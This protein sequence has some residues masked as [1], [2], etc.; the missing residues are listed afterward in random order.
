MAIAGRKPLPDQIKDFRGTL[1]KCRVN[2]DAVTPEEG[3]MMPPDILPEGAV[4]YFEEF[5]AMFARLHMS[6]PVYE[7][8][9]FEIA[10]RKYEIDVLTK[11][12][13][14]NGFVLDGIDKNGNP[15]RRT[16][17]AVSLRNESVRHLHALLAECGMT[18]SAATRVKRS[19]SG[20]E[21]VSG[22]AALDQE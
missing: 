15:I 9:V 14:D 16:N 1:R 12:I 22:F 4:K 17:P 5:A 10:L 18:P 8:L 13:E 11:D 20:E 19:S 7:T 6:S 3:P 2:K 21:E